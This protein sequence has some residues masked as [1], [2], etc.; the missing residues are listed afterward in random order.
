MRFVETSVFTKQI[1]DLLDADE[2]RALQNAMMMRSDAGSVIQ[3]SG[4]LRK[5]RWGRGST[6]R[7][8]GLRVIYYRDKATETFFMVFAYPK[9]V[10]RDLTASQLRI[11]GRV[12][13]EEFP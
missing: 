1:T 12:V 7:R 2:Y 9:N 3:G 10:Q 6:G 8:G 11:L 13:R 5:M 4:G